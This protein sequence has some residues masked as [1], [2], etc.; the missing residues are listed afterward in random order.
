MP[1]YSF[2]KRLFLNPVSTNLTSY[3]LVHVENS[4]EGIDKYG[5]NV[6]ILGDCDHKTMLEFFLGT[7]KARRLSLKKIDLLI[8]ILTAFRAALVKE[9]NSIEK[10]K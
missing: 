7:K 6:V 4:R 2:R 9:I 3:I 1:I 5:T 8:R 10:T